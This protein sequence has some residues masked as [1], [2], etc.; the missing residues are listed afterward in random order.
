MLG[1]FL[2]S[3]LDMSLKLVTRDT[4]EIKNESVPA[5]RLEREHIMLLII[6]IVLVIALSTFFIYLKR[7]QVKAFFKEIKMLQPKK[8][9][10][11][12]PLPIALLISG[13][14]MN[15]IHF[16]YA[17]V[18][19]GLIPFYLFISLLFP[20]GLFAPF[21]RSPSDIS[22]GMLLIGWILYAAIIVFGLIKPTRVAFI[23]L[24]LLL[25]L[26]IGGCQQPQTSGLSPW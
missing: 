15:G 12:L 25:V 22:Y 5:G 13:L 7:K 3:I 14:L 21:V 24:C 17:F 23:V 16:L 2:N 19:W 20:I 1:T 8:K 10:F 18:D 6:E 9:W 11:L 26:N 4:S